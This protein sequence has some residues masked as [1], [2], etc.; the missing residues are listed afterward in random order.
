MS[1]ASHMSMA[2]PV[3]VACQTSMAN[4]PPTYLRGNV[5]QHLVRG[6][7]PELDR[8]G[9]DVVAGAVWDLQADAVA[10]EGIDIEVSIPVPDVLAVAPRPLRGRLLGVAVLVLCALQHALA[11]FPLEINELLVDICG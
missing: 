10:L 7:R 4:P 9:I 3:C 5:F 1:S 2:S 11:L 6:A 8:R